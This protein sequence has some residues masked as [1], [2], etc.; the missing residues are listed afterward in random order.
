MNLNLANFL[1]SAKLLKK[2]RLVASLKKLVT[3]RLELCFA[4]MLSKFITFVLED[5]V[6]FMGVFA[7]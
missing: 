7:W 6:V 2:G 4:V 3:H 1:V 5:K